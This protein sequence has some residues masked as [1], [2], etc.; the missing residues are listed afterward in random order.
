[1]PRLRRWYFWRGAAVCGIVGNGATI[2]PLR[3]GENRQHSGRDDRRLRGGLGGVAG[4]EEHFVEVDLGQGAA[5]FAEGE[6]RNQEDGEDGHEGEDAFESA[7]TDFCDALGEGMVMKETD[8][9]FFD[10]FEKA[11]DERKGDG[12]E[13][14]GVDERRIAE[15]T[16]GKME[17]LSD[18]HN[19]GERQ[20]IEESQAVGNKGN[21]LLGEDHRAI[22]NEQREHQPEI[23]GEDEVVF[24]AFIDFLF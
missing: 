8:E 13:E 14:C 12:F 18:E 1:M 11:K 17:I 4:L 10:N 22:E 24:N 21:L 2:P 6:E 16:L 23:G 15:L 7:A 19:L 5:K 3:P 9:S 20:R